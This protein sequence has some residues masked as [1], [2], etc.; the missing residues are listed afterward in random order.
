ME[1]SSPVSLLLPLWSFIIFFIV[2]FGG[3]KLLQL[4][5]LF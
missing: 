1:G 2:G 4:V 5:G 3:V